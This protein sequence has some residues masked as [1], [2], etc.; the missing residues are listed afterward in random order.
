MDFVLTDD[1]M[2]AR[3]GGAIYGCVFTIEDQALLEGHILDGTSFR[4]CQL[5]ATIS[6]VNACLA[7]LDREVIQTDVSILAF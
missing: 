7:A 5:I 1:H 2:I 6:E 4:R 3:S